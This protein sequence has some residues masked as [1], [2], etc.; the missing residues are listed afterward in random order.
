M[1]SGTYSENST[2][3]PETYLGAPSQTD[4]TS[5]WSQNRPSNVLT[6]DAAAPESTVPSPGITAQFTFSVS[7][8]SSQ[9]EIDLFLHQE[10]QRILSFAVLA[11]LPHMALG[12]AFESLAEVY[13]LY[14]GVQ[15]PESYLVAPTQLRQ[16]L[17]HSE[18]TDPSSGVRGDKFIDP[19]LQKYYESKGIVV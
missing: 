15:M 4:S 12:D 18:P 11:M 16:A 14:W 17:A 5:H 3:L 10:R 19:A 9:E 13:E 8:T 1:K 6:W 2:P 7:G